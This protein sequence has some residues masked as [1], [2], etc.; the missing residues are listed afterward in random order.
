MA[1]RRA[2]H[3]DLGV[4]LALVAFDDDEIASTLRPGLTTIAI[5]H[6]KMGA[7]AI[8]LLTAQQQQLDDVLI[9]MD[10]VLRESIGSPTRS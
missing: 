7:T 9:P 6:E 5:P 2:A 3:F 10:V 4:A 8:D 1:R